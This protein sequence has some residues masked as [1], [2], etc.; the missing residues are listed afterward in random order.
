MTNMK[1]LEAA[2]RSESD[3]FMRR[4]IAMHKVADEV[5][6]CSWCSATILRIRADY[7]RRVQKKG[8]KIAA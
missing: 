3:G 5:E 8:R 7:K 1:F 4:T 6:D 2:I